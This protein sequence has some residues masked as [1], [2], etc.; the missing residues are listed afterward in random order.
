MIEAPHIARVEALPAAVIRLTIPRGEIRNVMGPAMAELK[1][2]LA[3]QRIPPA[4]PIFS[5]HF[6]I[7]PGVF[8][9]EVGIPVAASVAASGRVQPGV[10]PAATVARAIHRGDY[11]GLGDAWQELDAWI[12]AKGH[13]TAPGMWESYVVGPESSAP[14]ADWHTEL[15]RPV[16]LR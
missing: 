13:L 4:G 6:R 3:A 9:F 7:D 2:A 14:P 12:T 10:L 8:D 11:A 16:A 1:A 15:N 5:H